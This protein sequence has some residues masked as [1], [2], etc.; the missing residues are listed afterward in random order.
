MSQKWQTVLWVALAELFAMSLWFSAS[1]VA[2]VLIESWQLAPGEAAWLTM[3]VQI[4]FVVGAFLSALF[5]LADIWPPRL[6]FAGGALVGAGAN[7]LIAGYADGIGVAIVLRFF[8]GFALAAVYPVGMKIMAT[9][10]KEDRGLGLGLLVGALAAGSATPHLIRGLGGIDD[11]QLVFY[12]ASLLAAIGGLIVWRAGELGPFRAAPAPFRWRYVGEVWKDR[13]VRLANFGYLGHMWELYAMWTWLPLFLLEVYRR[14]EGNTGWAQNADTRAALASFAVIGVGALGCLAAGK[15]ADRW[16]RSLVTMTCMIASG[17]CALTI[18]FL[19]EFHPLLI[20]A[21]ALLWGLTVIP[22]SAQFSAAIS[23]LAHPQ[24]IGTAL[25]LQTSLGFLL[26]LA[27]IRLIPVIVQW[28]GWGGAFAM[29]ALGPLLGTWAM[30][31]LKR[32]PAAAQLA[33]GQG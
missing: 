28:M 2:P 7:A 15:L 6:V 1:A 4:G 22:D 32:S 9:W 25:T 21:L 19:L 11:W 5:N 13:G 16:G 3:A 23:E 10:M 12:V 17:A 8:T 27:S 18:G 14:A 30:W 20:T 31:R 29:L 24:Y 26:T 33:G